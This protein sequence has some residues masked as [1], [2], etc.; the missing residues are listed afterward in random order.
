MVS[1]KKKIAFVNFRGGFIPEN[2]IITKLLREKW[3][4]EI[5]DTTHADYVFFSDH[6]DDHWFVPDRIVKI[7]VTIENLVPDFNACDYGIGFEWMDYGDRYLRMPLYYTYPDINELVEKRHF[8]SF[9]DIKSEKT[10]FCSIT[11]SNANRDSIFCTLFD[12]LSKYKRVDSGGMWKNNI[13]GRVN[14]KMAF[15][16][17]HKFTIVCENS[18]HP[19]YTTEKIV[20]A[21][22]ANCIPIY[23]GDPEITR[24]FNPKA[25]IHVQNYNSVNDVLDYVIKVDT[26]DNLWK[27]M[28]REPV[29]MD[30]CFSKTNQEE[31]LRQFLSNI[32]NQPIEL[33]Y[34]RN[35][36]FWGELYVKDRRIQSKSLCHILYQ[37]YRV[38]TWKIKT[39]LRQK[40]HI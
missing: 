7:Y 13:G 21:F 12:T 22:A 17:S 11:V 6:G 16:R 8:Q 15:D 14:D 25:F 20:Q 5:T 35:R 27:S 30:S 19:G 34:R 18:A 26:N 10:E 33:A 2:N 23:W 4:V 3:D 9:N 1:S 32:F 38:L 28:V 37:Q 31:L 39:F 29:L 36:V 40:L 24:V